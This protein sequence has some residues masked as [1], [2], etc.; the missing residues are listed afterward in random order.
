MKNQASIYHLLKER[1]FLEA[2]R[3][4]LLKEKDELEAQRQFLAEM[5]CTK[6]KPSRHT[7]YMPNFLFCCLGA[8]AS[9]KWSK[10]LLHTERRQHWPTSAMPQPC[11]GCW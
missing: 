11:G 3:D 2:E 5:L 6:V 10:H 7:I 4:E 1:D 8:P 9:H